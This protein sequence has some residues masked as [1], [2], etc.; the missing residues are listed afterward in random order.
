MSKKILL[1]MAASSL[2]IAGAVFADND[3]V[4]VCHVTGSEKNPVVMISVSSSAVDAHLAHG[5]H[6]VPP[7]ADDCSGGGDPE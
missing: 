2:L 7:G 4:G 5:D 1:G 6:L 3:K